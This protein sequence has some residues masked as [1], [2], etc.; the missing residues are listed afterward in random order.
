[1]NK[2][3]E[4]LDVAKGILIISVVLSHSSFKLA[5][6]MYWFHMPAFFIISGIL[7]KNNMNFNYQL[8]KFYIPYILFSLID[9][10]IDFLLY[11]ETISLRKYILLLYHYL[12]SGKAIRGVFWFV[13]ALLISKYL[14]YIIHRYIN[15]PL[16]IPLIVLGYLCAHLYSIKVIPDSIVLIDEKYWVILGLDVVPIAL[17]Y[18]AMGYYSKKILN[19]IVSSYALILSFIACLYLIHINI[20]EGIYYYLNIKFAFF[21]YPILDLVYPLTFTAL[22]LSLSYFIKESNLGKALSYCGV[23]SLIIMYLHK[24][25][26][27]LILFKYK[28]LGWLEVSLISIIISIMVSEIIE[29]RSWSVEFH[30]RI[31]RK[32]Y[33]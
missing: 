8:K 18:Y 29:K 26:M 3:I 32:K 19:Y 13:P 33:T 23:N 14:F 25:I 7:F 6:Y 15:K 20:E 1:M 24:P 11:P 10:N 9:L 16:I 4:Y 2:R 28:E 31:L 5:Q 21:K 30:K 27:I 17:T 12:F 22:I